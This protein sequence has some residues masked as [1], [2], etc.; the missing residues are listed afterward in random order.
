MIDELEYSPVKEELL[1]HYCSAATLQAIL[2]NRSLRLCDLATMNDSME[3]AW[4]AKLLAEA[5]EEE[6]MRDLVKTSV[7]INEFVASFLDAFRVL[8]CCFST[9]RD[10]L[11]QWRAYA[12]NGAGFCIGISSSLLR[13]MKGGKLRVCY[14]EPDQRRL[15]SGALEKGLMNSIEGGILQE[16][17]FKSQLLSLIFDLAGMKNPAF[18]EESEVRWTHLIA[19]EDEGGIERL[20]FPKQIKNAPKIKYLMRGSMPTPYVDVELPK[21][22]DAIKEV[23]I[24]P[25]AGVGERQIQMMLGTLGFGSAKVMTSTASYR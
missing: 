20:R 13:S 22:Q 15:L 7:P 19:V 25:R 1:Y 8:A 16:G 21:G 23:W 3:L 10:Q 24:G 14:D 5:L 18:K 11:S 2:T 9:K 6:Q 12:D 17:K 4:G